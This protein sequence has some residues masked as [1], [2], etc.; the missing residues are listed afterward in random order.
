MLAKIQPFEVVFCFLLLQPPHC[1]T[2][3]KDNRKTS[4]TPTGNRRSPD[5]R[6][7][8]NRIG[9][10]KTAITPTSAGV[11][12]KKNGSALSL[13]LAQKNSPSSSGIDFPHCE[14]I[15]TGGRSGKLIIER[16]LSILNP[17]FSVLRGWKK[18]KKE[19]RQSKGPVE[20]I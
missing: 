16:K 6:D 4:I 8:S 7:W 2:A 18:G 11:C 20:K 14:S 13:R 12:W 5:G 3:P 10:A 15:R 17:S 1:P 9:T 19:E